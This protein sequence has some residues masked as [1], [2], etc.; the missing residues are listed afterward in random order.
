M[1]TDNTQQGVT[2]T[3][4]T[5]EVSSVVG[6][7]FCGGGAGSNTAIADV[8]D[9]KLLRLR[10]L[11][12]NWQYSQEELNE[13]TMEARGKTFQAKYKALIPPFSLGYKKRVYSSNRVK[14]PLKRVDFDPSG[15]PG[16]TGPGGRNTQNR[17][18]SKF[19]RIGW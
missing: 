5:N 13:W 10:P 19:K 8:K 18:K 4:P 16:S 3:D 11:P 2:R 7:G 14:Y 1:A 15:A 6:L 9:G 12:L 17:G